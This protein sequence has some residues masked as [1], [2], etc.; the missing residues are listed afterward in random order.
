MTMSMTN[1]KPL[2]VLLFIL[3][4]W[5]TFIVFQNSTEVGIAF[6]LYFRKIYL[7]DTSPVLVQM[8]RPIDYSRGVPTAY[9]N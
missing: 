9:T 4:S 8:T 6:F 7:L 3:A 2:L 1:R 5:I